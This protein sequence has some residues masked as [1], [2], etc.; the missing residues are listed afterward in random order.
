MPGV[1]PVFDPRAIVSSLERHGVVYVLI[2]GLARVLRGA[3]ET[4]TGVDICTAYSPD[5]LERLTS[6]VAELGATRAD[7]LELVLTDRAMSDERVIALSTGYGALNIVGTPAGVTRGCVDLR[8]AASRENL[9]HGLQPYV[10][11]AGDLAGMAAALHR[12]EDIARLPELRRIMELEVDRRQTI[13]PPQPAVRG[14]VRHAHTLDQDR[15][16]LERGGPTLRP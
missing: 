4:T 2:G 6:A 11:S 9:G 7:G 13:A 5:N 14:P 16:G 8:R 12:E 1:E 3:D 15:A 10:A